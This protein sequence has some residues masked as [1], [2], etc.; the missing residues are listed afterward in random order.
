MSASA[1]RLARLGAA[2]AAARQAEEVQLAAN[3]AER[4]R[5]A[6][7]A[8]ALRERG[9]AAVEPTSASAPSGF[10]LGADAHWRA[11]L[12]AAARQCE[13]RMQAL[14]EDAEPIRQRLATLLAREQAVA[15]LAE[16]A[17]AEAKTAALRRSETVPQRS[18]ISAPS[19]S[20]PVAPEGPSS[21]GIA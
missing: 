15:D 8:E 2:V 9:G 4:R 20:D 1:A 3:W 17:V 13:A 16:R 7:E 19:A 6:R 21:V 5:L 12:R 14:G 18:S 11:S 10:D